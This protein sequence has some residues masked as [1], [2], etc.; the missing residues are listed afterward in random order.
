[1]IGVAVSLF[2][3]IHIANAQSQCATQDGF[4]PL[5]CFERSQK[6]SEAYS[7]GD[8]S[9]FLQRVFVGAISLGGIL[10]VLRLAWGGFMYMSSDL[11][12][13][14]EHAKEV[15]RETLLGLFLLLA[16]YTILYQINPNILSLNLSVQNTEDPYAFEDARAA[17]T[18]S[19]F[20]PNG[21]I[22]PASNLNIIPQQNFERNPAAPA[23]APNLNNCD[24][25]GCIDEST[26]EFIPGGA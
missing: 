13:T 5:E 21:S 18:N 25:F 10:A 8:L 22:P 1:M 6:L 26:G 23:P 14:K 16:V 3:G 11:W 20:V 24:G 9:E 7:S 19:N 2:I 17:R 15:I 4:V 12:S